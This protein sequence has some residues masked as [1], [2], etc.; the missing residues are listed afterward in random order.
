MIRYYL[1]GT[2]CNPKNKD[3][4]NYVFDFSDRQLRELELS[5]DTLE[6]V[7]EDFDAIKQWIDLYG[8]F[9]GMPLDIKYS[10]GTIVKYLLDFADSNFV[11]QQRGCKVK[12]KRY[13]SVDNFFDNADGLSFGLIK[14][15]QSDFRE[16][17]YVIIPEQ[18]GSYY[19]SLALAT[20]ALAQELYRSIQEIAEAVADLTKALVPVGAPVPG[21][22]WGAIAVAAIKLAARIAYAIVIVIALVKLGAEIINLI[23]QPIR[24]FK[25]VGFKRLIQRGCE[26]LGYTLESNLLNQLEALTV[27]P[28]PLKPKDPNWFYQLLGVATNGYTNGYPSSRDTIQTLGQ[29][30]KA[31]ENTF[32]AKTVILNGVVRIEQEMYFEQTPNTTLLNAFNLQDKLQSEYK[33][34]ADE[35]FKRMVIQYRVD[36][37]DF[38]TFDD[39]HRNLYE[40][41]S[42]VL[43]SPDKS[44]E[45]IKGFDLVDIP[46]ARGT[47]KGNLN[48]LEAAAKA[49]AKAL[50][51]F[52]GGNLAA[53][54]E[55]RKNTMQISSQYFNVTK[56]L[57][58]QGTKLHP[59]QT[60][61]I[62]C[63]VI[64]QQYWQSRYIE[65]VQKNVYENLPI[66]MTEEQLFALLQNNFQVMDDG[67]VAEFWN[68]QWSE[69]QN[70]ATAT[71]RVPE[72]PINV[73]TIVIDAGN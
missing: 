36:A 30:I 49:Y 41:S 51:N 63:Q 9:V 24:Q 38:N 31:I 62:G 10:N 42:E 60:S 65:N 22:D 28:V 21:P 17:D 67:T 50:D 47:S 14:W 29:A 5:V 13:K 16:V 23:F 19:I 27:L 59:D 20:F 35:V 71:I 7:R 45:L 48:F 2:E 26:Y 55:A 68:I 4:V 53:K 72:K 52:T 37:S 8:R 69:I 57:W 33:T 11:M 54:I 46:F 1:N 3:S 39:T 12:I 32:N 44:F 15:N 18:Q 58:M 56:L 43:T 34:N 40:V 64:A 6:F 61:K 70:Y 73:K 25:G 66:A